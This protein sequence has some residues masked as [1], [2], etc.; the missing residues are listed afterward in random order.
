MM[1]DALLLVGATGS[2]LTGIGALYWGRARL[3]MAEAAIVWASRCHP[4]NPSF[5]PPSISGKDG[6]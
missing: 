2:V 6:K 3:K 1:Y 5:K 4:K